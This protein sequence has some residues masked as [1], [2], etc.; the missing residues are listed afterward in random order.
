M[1]LFVSTCQSS[2]CLQSH[3]VRHT[4]SSRVTV[5]IFLLVTDLYTRWFVLAAVRHPWLLCVWFSR[6]V[7]VW[8]CALAYTSLYKQRPCGLLSEGEKNPNCFPQGSVIIFTFFRGPFFDVRDPSLTSTI[9][10]LPSPLLIASYPH[11]YD[12]AWGKKIRKKTGMGYGRG[13]RAGERAV[14]ETELIIQIQS[15]KGKC[16][17]QA[18]KMI[19]GQEQI[20]TNALV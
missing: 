16:V 4:S 2:D 14:R 8:E 15:L 17:F 18:V 6:T 1:D 11:A 5:F 7:T 20:L 13:G 12:C 19:N 10:P 3:A 9:P